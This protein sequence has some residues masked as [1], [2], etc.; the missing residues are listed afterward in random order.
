MIELALYI[1]NAMS[2]LWFVISIFAV[3]YFACIKLESLICKIPFVNS[4]VE[5]PCETAK[6]L[7]DEGSLKSIDSEP[8]EKPLSKLE[9]VKVAKS[10]KVTTKKGPKKPIPEGSRPNL[11]VEKVTDVFG[12]VAKEL[13]ATEKERQESKTN[14]KKKPSTKKKANPE[15]AGE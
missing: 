2:I 4:K 6:K 8:I 9:T 11:P 15:I 3:F 14:P 7:I 13:E 1:L 5:E 10:K 12:L